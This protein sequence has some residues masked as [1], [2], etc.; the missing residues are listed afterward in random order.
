LPHLLF[1]ASAPRA[2]DYELTPLHS[3]DYDR[4]PSL[5]HS[6]ECCRISF[7]YSTAT[8]CGIISEISLA[9]AESRTFAKKVCRLMKA[10]FLVY[11]AQRHY[12]L[13]GGVIRRDAA[14][15]P[16]ILYVI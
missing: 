6:A 11:L 14:I 5:P 15:S 9:D 8:S 1:A 12:M 13:Y 7:Y 2:R 10:S 3:F 16:P 4:E